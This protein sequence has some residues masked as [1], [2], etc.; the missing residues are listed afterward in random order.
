MSESRYRVANGTDTRRGILAVKVECLMLSAC[1]TWLK[2]FMLRL[3]TYVFFVTLAAMPPLSNWDTTTPGAWTTI[4]VT[5]GTGI[6]V[7]VGITA[8]AAA[9]RT[10]VT[11]GITAAAAKVG[12][13]VTVA[14][15]LRARPLAP[16]AA[17]TAAATH[18]LSG[19]DSNMVTSHSEWDEMVE[20]VEYKSIPAVAAPPQ[21]RL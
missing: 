18:L 9:V 6:V 12:T 15:T 3:R 14:S 10:W 17:G 5:A 8:A 7:T 19:E 4:P 16:V 1:I 20:R 2:E 21:R 11:V 13:W